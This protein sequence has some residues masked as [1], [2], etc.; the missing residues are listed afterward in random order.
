MVGSGV[1]RSL[2]AKI[3]DKV[4]HEILI[5]AIV[6][7]IESIFW[8]NQ[9]R[10]EKIVHQLNSKKQRFV[11]HRYSNVLFCSKYNLNNR[12]KSQNIV[13]RHPI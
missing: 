10:K 5:D 7:A 9:K 6:K 13:G 8:R 3:I 2:F 12:Y 11:L 1:K 4:S